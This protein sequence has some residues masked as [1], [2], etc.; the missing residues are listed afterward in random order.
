MSP[1]N[2]EANFPSLP[3]NEQKKRR[4]SAS[5]PVIL[6]SQIRNTIVERMRA[7]DLGSKEEVRRYL[8]ENPQ[9]DLSIA[10]LGINTRT[11]NALGKYLEITQVLELIHCTRE[12]VR[13]VPN[14]GEAG[15]RELLDVLEARGF[16]PS[17]AHAAPSGAKPS[18]RTA[19]ERTGTGKSTAD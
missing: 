12:E 17:Q 4:K 8:A 14:I 16:I 5:K 13:A 7:N 6:P 9:H 19:T 1:I 15:L 18:R 10:D 2:P 11:T 3:G